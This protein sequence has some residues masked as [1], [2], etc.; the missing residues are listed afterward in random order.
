M[1]SELYQT[2]LNVILSG[3][4]DLLESH[5]GADHLIGQGKVPLLNVAAKM[6]HHEAICVLATRWTNETDDYGRTALMHACLQGDLESAKLLL[7]QRGRVN[8]GGQTALIYAAY[9]NALEIIKL[10]ISEEEGRVCSQGKTALMVA[11]MQDHPEAVTLLLCEAGIQGPDGTTALML[12]RSKAVVDMLLGSEGRLYRNDGFTPLMSAACRNLPT[13]IEALLEQVPDLLRL[14]TRSKR[15]ALMFAAEMGSTRCMELLLGE[16]GMQDDLGRTALMFAMK[17]GCSSS[18]DLLLDSECSLCDNAGR[19][20]SSYTSSIQKKVLVGVR[21]GGDVDSDGITTLMHA[22]QLDDLSAVRMVFET[23]KGM[24]DINGDTA[25][26]HA[27]R[28]HSLSVISLLSNDPELSKS[29]KDGHTAILVCALNGFTEAIPYLLKELPLHSDNLWDIALCEGHVDTSVA[30]LDA[31]L[32]EVR[33]SPEMLH[34]F[35]VGLYARCAE[36]AEEYAY[37]KEGETPLLIWDALVGSVVDLDDYID[38]SLYNALSTCSRHASLQ[39][40]CICLEL[41]VGVIFLPC[42]HF[43]CCETCATTIV[44][45]CPVCRRQVEDLLV[46]VLWGDQSAS[47]LTS[48]LSSAL[49]S[50][51]TSAAR[52]SPQHNRDSY[53]ELSFDGSLINS[54]ISDASCLSN[55]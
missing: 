26:I 46:P 52:L 30:L 55:F 6:G 4:L 2:Q 34:T 41:E 36:I 39:T 32:Q 50:S 9:T 25:L 22:A 16:V 45:A 38:G 5:L 20:A 19:Y 35:T 17:T 10:L 12:A 49:Q 23:Q 33:F 37:I 53:S 1:T 14:S 28:N 31:F 51:G 8:H 48:L 13:V 11:A 42:H 40:C 3:S 44:K 15:T 29:N 24:Q 43:A 47:A 27:C 54:T 21:V 7:C 18:I